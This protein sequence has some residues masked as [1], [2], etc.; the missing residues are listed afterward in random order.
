MKNWVH[1]TGTSGTGARS[2]T[3]QLISESGYLVFVLEAEWPSTMSLARQFSVC[4]VHIA[5]RQKVPTCFHS[6]MKVEAS[7][8]QNNNRTCRSY[9]PDYKCRYRDTPVKETMIDCEINRNR[10]DENKCSRKRHETKATIK[11]HHL[12][13]WQK[14]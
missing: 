11:L 4:I 3:L 10:N 13:R 9:H 14:Q 12:R 8:P 7:K 1:E 5:L 6:S 2:S